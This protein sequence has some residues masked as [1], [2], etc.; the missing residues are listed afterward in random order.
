[1]RIRRLG[2]GDPGPLHIRRRHRSIW[3]NVQVILFWQLLVS[4][5]CVYMRHTVRQKYLIVKV[6][7]IL[8][9]GQS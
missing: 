2:A 8:A 3:D 1:M 9:L 4:K 7:K 5:I 6:L